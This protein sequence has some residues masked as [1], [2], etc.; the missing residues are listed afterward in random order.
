MTRSIR[1]NTNPAFTLIEL[2]VAISI[3]AVLAA[4]L[5]P[6]LLQAKVAGQR[7]ASISNVKEQSLSLLLYANDNDDTYPVM[8][9]CEPYTSLNPKFLAPQY[10]APSNGVLM[11][12]N[13]PYYNCMNNLSWQK[14]TRAYVKTFNI[15]LDPLREKDEDAWNLNG[16]LSNQFL[17]NNG[18]TGSLDIQSAGLDPLGRPTLRGVRESWLHGR[19]S[20]I[21]RPSE[22]MILME[23]SYSIGAIPLMTDDSQWNQQT[24]EIIG[25]PICF[26]EY[27]KNK[28]YLTPRGALD[29]YADTVV[30]VVDTSKAVQGGLT[31]GLVDGSARYYPANRFLAQCPSKRDVLPS[32]GEDEDPGQGYTFG[33]DCHGMPN[34]TTS[35][36]QA[37]NL[38]VVAGFQP[39]GSWPM[40]GLGD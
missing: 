9:G 29:C 31:V 4:L 23:A 19:M 37:A 33:D 40:W 28:F 12:C 7:A 3:I 24:Q 30:P 13:N 32:L 39:S 5:F 10:N 27:W 14:W 8:D 21:N 17:L 18:L 11:G 16:Q 6:V 2:L 36:A 15:F 26:R 38:G 20:A 22:A 25:Y 35:G 34:N 1:T